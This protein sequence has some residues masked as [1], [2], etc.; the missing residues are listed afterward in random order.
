MWRFETVAGR[1]EILARR[2]GKNELDAIQASL[3]YV[4]AQNEYAE[5]DRTDAGVK[6]YA[7]RILSQPGKRDGLF[8]PT[9]Q[10]ESSVLLANSSPRQPR[11]ATVAVADGHRFTAT[12]SK[13]SQSRAPLPPAAS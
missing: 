13:S 3:A 2:I 4:D 12:I 1:H 7:Q 11:R 8:W 5:K 9:S 10:G 6:T